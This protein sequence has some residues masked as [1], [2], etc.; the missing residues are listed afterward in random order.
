M[1]VLSSSFAHK[2]DW[3]ISLCY[4]SDI[5]TA[6]QKLDNIFWSVLETLTRGTIPKSE[7]QAQ[8]S[9]CFFDVNGVDWLKRKTFQQVL[10]PPP[11][12]LG[13]LGLR[14]LVET[15]PAAFVGGVEMCIPHFTGH[16]GICQ[17]FSNANTWQTSN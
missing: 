2:L 5:K 4:P 9:N 10:I 6:A 7:N 15:S 16:E 1:G 13:G 14:S 3:H 8:P 11:I 12:K 17:G